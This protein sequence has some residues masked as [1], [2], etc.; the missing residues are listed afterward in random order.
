MRL[1]LREIIV[2][3]ILVA[4]SF[5]GHYYLSWHCTLPPSGRYI[6]KFFWIST[7]V[8]TGYLGL[9]KHEISWI[10]TLWVI[11]NGA[12]MVCFGIDKLL[13]LYFHKEPV[14]RVASH[15]F[16][17]PIP[18]LA[19]CIVPRIFIAQLKKHYKRSNN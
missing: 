10:S 7:M 8:I 14:F 17:V 6:G 9:L 13:L 19:A 4:L 2:L 3:A 12:L 11:I 15:L 18:F 1:T 5:I 16:T